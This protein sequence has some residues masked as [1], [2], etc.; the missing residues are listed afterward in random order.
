MFSENTIHNAFVKVYMIEDCS[1]YDHF[2]ACNI[3]EV[4]FESEQIPFSSRHINVK[5]VNSVIDNSCAI[6]VM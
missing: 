1:A 2:L 4:K 5:D 3:F 6:P